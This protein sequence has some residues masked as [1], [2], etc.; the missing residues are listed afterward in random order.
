[1]SGKLPSALPGRGWL[2]PL[3]MA[4]RAL[5]SRCQQARSCNGSRRG[6]QRSGDWR[7]ESGE[8]SAQ[9]AEQVMD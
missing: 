8:R 3:A 2:T 1:M 5:S 6:E 4:G 7:A 9:T